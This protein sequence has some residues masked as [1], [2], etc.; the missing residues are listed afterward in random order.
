MV[1][2]MFPTT[3]F[4]RP[5]ARAPRGS[6]ARSRTERA[7][8]TR[9]RAAHDGVYSE[10][11]HAERAH[12]LAEGEVLAVDDEAVANWRYSSP[13]RA[14][15]ARAPAPASSCRL[16]LSAPYRRRT[17]VTATT[18]A[19]RLRIS[20]RMPFSS[21]IGRMPWYGL[22]ADH[23]RFQIVGVQRI[24]HFVG[25][26]R[27]SGSRVLQAAHR[28]VAAQLVVILPGTSSHRRR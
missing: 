12:A 2:R 25:D 22:R 7:S 27:F 14:R 19:P 1:R 18:G 4:H 9:R 10:H 26:A 21:R 13:R 28:G 8:A 17:G 3:D 20:S 11:L 6:S 23:H 5:R 24:E 16:S 15:R